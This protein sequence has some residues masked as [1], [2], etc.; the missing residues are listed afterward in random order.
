MHT[1]DF[2]FFPRVLFKVMYTNSPF[3]RSNFIQS[4]FIIIFLE[5]VRAGISAVVG[6]A[7]WNSLR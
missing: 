7:A 2:V 3:T 4:E 5:D 6:S 1:T